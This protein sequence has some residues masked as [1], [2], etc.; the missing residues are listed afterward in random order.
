MPGSVNTANYYQA[1]HSK[2]NFQSFQWWVLHGCKG[3]ILFLLGFRLIMF[4]LSACKLHILKR[5]YCRPSNL[6]LK[7]ADGY[8]LYKDQCVG[9]FVRN[10]IKNRLEFIWMGSRYFR[11]TFV[12]ILTSVPPTVSPAMQTR[13]AQICPADSAATAKSDLLLIL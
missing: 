6:N 13:F 5:F 2:R 7:C 4:A 12:Q 10:V 8:Q 3:C 1:S 11:F 9:E